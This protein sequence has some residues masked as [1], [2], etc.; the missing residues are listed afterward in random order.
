MTRL[1]RILKADLCLILIFATLA[2]AD[3]EQDSIVVFQPDFFEQYNPITALDLVRRVPGFTIEIT[4][5]I[6]NRNSDQVRGFGGAAGNVIINGVRPSTK[7]DG[8][9]NILGRIAAGNVERIELY[10]GGTGG[11]DVGAAQGVV[12]NVV[13]KEGAGGGGTYEFTIVERKSRYEPRLNLSYNNKLGKT[14]YTVALERFGF[15]IT[16]EGPETLTNFLGP[17]EIRLEEVSGGD[18]IWTADLQTQ[19]RLTDRDVLRFNLKGSTILQQEFEDSY[20]TPSGQSEP[21]LFALTEREEKDILE[22]GSDYEHKFSDVFRAKIIGLINRTYIDETSVLNIERADD[23][24]SLSRAETQST[25]GETIGRIELDWTKFKGHAIQFG[26][27]VAKNYVDS[28]FQLFIDNGQGENEVILPGANTRVSEIRGEAFLSDS[29]NISDTLT[30]D[31]GFNVEASEITQSGD[32]DNA[33]SFVFAKPSATLTYVVGANSQWR[34]RFLR[35]VG[36][37]DFFDFVSSTNFQDNDVDLGNPDLQP[38]ATWAGELTYEYRFGEIGVLELTGFYNYIENVIDLLPTGPTTESAGNIGNGK[39][40]GIDSK[41]TTGFDFVGI[42]NMRMDVTYRLQASS[43]EDPVTGENRRFSDERK[44]DLQVAMRKEFPSVRS[45]VGFEYDN[46]NPKREYGVDE[47]AFNGRVNRLKLFFETI[48]PMGM[49]FRT[50]I[51]DTL[52]QRRHEGR[53]VYNGSRSQSD[54][55]FIESRVRTHSTEL[56]FTISGVF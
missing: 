46:E 42:P 53:T 12:V 52:N 17:D 54:I 10:R 56:F 13:L 27:E 43:V 2:S 55:A 37:L 22:F 38:D 28:E 15:D 19:T 16:K 4:A 36:Q 30:A 7:S 33:R 26:A 8:V 11:L 1:Y 20:R 21:D 49:K 40:W 31:L 6:N 24:F 3:G 14:D 50:E 47:I 23:T 29:W 32:V 48:L 45:T 39:R 18:D 41:F 44:H 35:E 34:L 25:E 9:D 5:N 51:K